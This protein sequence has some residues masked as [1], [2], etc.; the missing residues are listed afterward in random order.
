MLATVVVV[1]V[2]VVV[3]LALC[4]RR[5]PTFWWTFLA[6]DRVHL[7]LHLVHEKEQSK[8]LQHSSK[9][10]HQWFSLLCCMQK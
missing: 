5:W 4:S 2:V 7:D 6:L 10:Y 1:V 9:D 8:V 3:I